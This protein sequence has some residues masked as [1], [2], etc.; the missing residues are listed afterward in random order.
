M[1]KS[2][3]ATNTPSETKKRKSANHGRTKPIR[4]GTNFTFGALKKVPLYVAVGRMAYDSNKTL[5][6]RF[7]NV[8]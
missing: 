1:N 2:K 8:V 6:P 5:M 7:R 3:K 4:G